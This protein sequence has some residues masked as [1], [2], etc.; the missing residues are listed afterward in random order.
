M[1]F[2]LTS[3]GFAQ[4]LKETVPL[5]EPP[6]EGQSSNAQVVQVVEALKHSDFL[7]HNYVL[8]EDAGT[9]KFMVASFLDYK[10]VDS[11][12]VTS[13]VQDMHVLIHD[14]HAEGMTLSETFKLL[15]LLKS[16]LQAE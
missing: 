3:L 7:C 16:Y 12:N 10:M 4:F 2:Y 14:I 8:N 5:V 13:Q 11:K 15:R 6:A 1:F 9:K